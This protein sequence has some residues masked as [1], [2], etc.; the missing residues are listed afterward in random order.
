MIVDAQGG[1]DTITV[2]DLFPTEVVTLNLILGAA[3]AAIDSVVVNM[4]NV[5][6]NLILDTQAAGSV[7]IQG[8]RY[9]VNLSTAE[10]A[11]LLR[12]NTNEGD[13]TV[14]SST[15]VEDVLG[16]IIDGG[17][18]N[19]TL[20]AQTTAGSGALLIGDAGND[21][22]IGGAGD[23]A[24]DGGAGDDSIDGRGGIDLITA[25]PMRIP[26]WLLERMRAM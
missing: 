1:G 6:D 5:A 13:D 22:L 21:T 16:L 15:G 24:I 3:D 2:E 18:G 12:V 8:L 11:D 9:N 7:R 23:D 20:T 17:L 10:P 25:A 14:L 4:R 26:S 19:D